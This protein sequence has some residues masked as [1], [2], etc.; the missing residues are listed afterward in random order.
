MLTA[1]YA[2][3]SVMVLGGLGILVRGAPF[4]G[5]D[6]GDTLILVGTM[7]ACSG[8]LLAGLATVLAALK[9]L[10]RELAEAREHASS[11]AAS[12]LYGEAAG[13]RPTQL[14]AEPAQT[15]L[16]AEAHP[17]TEVHEFA[18]IRV[19]ATA[20]A[21]VSPDATASD[22]AFFL[23]QP[24]HLE[25]FPG[26]SAVPEPEP[27]RRAIPEFLTRPRAPGPVQDP[28]REPERPDLAQAALTSRPEGDAAAAGA[29][30]PTVP[31]VESGEDPV[32]RVE[33][34]WPEA[35]PPHAGTALD[36]HRGKPGY[37]HPVVIPDEAAPVESVAAADSAVPAADADH[38]SGHEAE[39]P[40]PQEIGRYSSGGNSYVMFADGSIEAETP[41]GKFRFGS[42]D[43]LKQFIASGGERSASATG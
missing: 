18:P 38:P 39:E 6:W 24:P 12:A 35:L 30:R 17:A 28:Y 14:S 3:A 11:S 43:E 33:D 16:D 42:L 36:E 27:S 10:A 5:V 19:A 4:I 40:P 8:A 34:D 29:H 9:G 2:I 23:A 26:P 15:E 13:L 21:S 20:P 31:I 7:T 37:Q 22:A 1:L 25:P 41:N 32:Q